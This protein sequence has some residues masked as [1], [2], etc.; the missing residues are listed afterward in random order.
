MK[1]GNGPLQQLSTSIDLAGAGGH[2]LN[3]AWWR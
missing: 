1:D 3:R 2:E